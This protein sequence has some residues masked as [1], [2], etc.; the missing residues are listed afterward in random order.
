M[1][2]MLANSDHNSNGRAQS[3]SA[4]R[5]ARLKLVRDSSTGD[6]PAE[7]K[8]FRTPSA[9][10]GVPQTRQADVST[11][12]G[13]IGAA[14]APLDRHIYNA[15][16]D[17]L[18]SGVPFANRQTGAAPSVRAT[19]LIT[20]LREISGQVNRMMSQ[21]DRAIHRLGEHAGPLLRR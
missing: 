16:S 4:F 18:L 19:D 7:H 13:T 11:K 5:P 21:V 12:H 15:E 17:V 10:I 9:S 8:V 1:T 20:E 6:L 3:P 14:V 2:P